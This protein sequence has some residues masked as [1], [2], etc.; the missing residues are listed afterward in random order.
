MVRRF[1]RALALAARSQTP[2]WSRIAAECGYYDQAHLCRDW[3]DLTGLSPQEFIGQRG[4]AVK[5]NHVAVPDED[6]N[7]GQYAAYPQKYVAMRG[8][9]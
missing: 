2:G 8:R 5:D 9:H 7:A 3:Q 6:A 1:Q 4:L